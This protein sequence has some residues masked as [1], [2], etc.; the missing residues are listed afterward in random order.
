MNFVDDGMELDY[1][2]YVEEQYSDS[3]EDNTGNV[4]DV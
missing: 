4:A 2:D 1:S 3:E